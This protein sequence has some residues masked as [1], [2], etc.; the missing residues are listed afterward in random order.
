MD[1]HGEWGSKTCLVSFIA[2]PLT[3]TWMFLAV[4]IVLDARSGEVSS[5]TKNAMTALT[6][7]TLPTY[8]II[9]SLLSRLDQ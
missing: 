6:L 4:V 7:L 1:W 9:K 5:D 8:E 2:L 3:Y